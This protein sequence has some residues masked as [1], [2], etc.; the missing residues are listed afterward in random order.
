MVKQ[1]VVRP[2][3]RWRLRHFKSVAEADVELA[4]LTVLVG[5]NSSGKSSLLQSM[6]LV[7]QAAQSYSNESGL[8][9]NGR[10]V[11]LGE[12]G[13]LRFAGA[14]AR[15]PVGIGGSFSLPVDSRTV[16]WDAEFGGKRGADGPGETQ[17]R[18]ILM[19]VPISH[20]GPGGRSEGIARFEARRRSRKELELGFLPSNRRRRVIEALAGRI[21][22]S[23]APKRRAVVRTAGV[24]HRAGLPLSILVTGDRNAVLVAE[25]VRLVRFALRDRRKNPPTDW[26]RIRDRRRDDERRPH[27]DRS[28]AARNERATDAC[29]RLIDAVA[30]AVGAGPAEAE[31]N[32]LLEELRGESMRRGFWSQLDA[33]VRDRKFVEAI[34]NVVGTGEPVLL[35]A[36]DSHHAAAAA[37]RLEECSSAISDLM[38]N[39]VL[40][41][42][43]LRQDPQLLYL[44][45]P[46]EARGFVG[47]KGEHAYAVLHQ[48]AER[49]VT[50]P[51]PAGGCESTTLI[52]AV[53]RWLEAFELADSIETLYRPRLGLEPRIR[54]SHVRAPLNM[55][56]VGVG[57][58]QVLPVLVMGLASDPGSV[59]LLEQPELHLH[60]AMQQRLADFLLGCVRCG[61]QVIVETHSDHLVTRLRR[62]I[63]EDAEDLLV[64]QV[65][66][67]FTE[68]LDGR[69]SFRGLASN[70]FGGIDEWP[71][72]FFDQGARDTQCLL[73]AGLEKKKR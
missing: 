40:Y 1:Q 66:F 62:R 55:T 38:A 56:A 50:C 53:N 18:S 71:A 73:K 34:E 58:S 68:R 4:P 72:G 14:S 5:A 64:E 70:R 61:R 13:D 65:G 25:W 35:P 63:A 41:L 24:G 43:P 17:L 27:G 23:G 60:P 36:A 69:T 57:V 31:L 39:R 16:K 52:V 47:T 54:M 49:Q 15:G 3:H 29:D 48:Q 45:A 30:A 37:R 9:L 2:I 21:D 33:L 67:V 44:T 51:T 11:E 10:F 22:L 7:S 28:D 20:G 32:T 6:L 19:E 12:L 8:P 26:D 59:L 42:G 46:T